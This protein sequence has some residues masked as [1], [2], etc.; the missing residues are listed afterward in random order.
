MSVPPAMPEQR[1]TPLE[2]FFDLVFVFAFTEVT[3]LLLND[4]TWAGLGRGALILA[5]LWWAWASYAWLTNAVDANVG[6]L[7]GPLLVAAA[8]MFVAALAVPEAFGDHGVVFGVAFLIVVAMQI[9]LFVLSSRGDHDVVATLLRTAPSQFAGAVLIL[10]AGFTD[11]ALRSLLWLAA[12]VL[13]FGVPLVTGVGGLRVEP[14]H[15]AERHALIVIIAIGEAL[16]ATGLGASDTELSARVITAAVLGF[17]VATSFWLAYFDFFAI[18]GRRLL[19]ERAGPERTTL[20]RDIYTYLHLPLVAGIVLFAFAMERTLAH[21][22]S[23]LDRIKAFA[24][25]GGSALNLFGY[26]AIRLRVSGSVRGGRTVACV[27]CLV[28]IPV[29]AHMSAVGALAVVTAVWVG[30]HAYEL[31]WW[32]QERRDVRAVASAS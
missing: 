22:S 29:A 13:V 7:W 6:L 2:L 17:V 19:D 16:I 4:P 9:T 21:P 20:A 8:A 24:L 3:Q 31:I 30:L 5:A 32:R 10:A 12:L 28:L 1:V 18:R 27:A 26:I 14:A 11:G 15:F 25:C 23:D